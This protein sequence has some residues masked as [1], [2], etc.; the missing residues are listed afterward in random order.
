MLVEEPARR[1]QI[2]NVIDRAV[3]APKA[4]PEQLRSFMSLVYSRWHEVEY[5]GDYASWIE[6][7]RPT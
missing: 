4:T 3:S 1:E 6:R 2:S 5:S 7:H